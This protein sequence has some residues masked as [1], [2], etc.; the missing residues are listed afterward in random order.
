L[1]ASDEVSVVPYVLSFRAS[2]SAD[3]RRLPLPARPALELWGRFGRPRVDHRL[4][5]ADLVHGTNYV[6]PPSRRPR[7]VSVYDC[8]ALENLGRV[9]ADVRAAMRVLRRSIDEGAHVHAS[10]HATAERLRG[11]FPDCDVTVVHLGDLTVLSRGPTE[12]ADIP[13][14][15]VGGSPYVVSIGTRE[16]RKN[17]ATLVRAFGAVAAAHSDVRLVLAGGAGDDD[18]V[19]DAAIA[20]LDADARDRVVV[21]GRVSDATATWL[22]DRAAVLAYP[23]LDEGFGFPLLEAMAHGTPIV[24]SRVGSIPEVAGDAA[25]LVGATETDAWSEAII[26]LLTDSELVGDLIARGTAQRQ[27]FSWERTTKQMIELYRRVAASGS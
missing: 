14:E 7:L 19:I 22:L 10:S 26:R 21:L 18:P 23:S 17:L 12:G 27:Q 3:T 16:R 9:H 24:A 15:L 5:G 25:L 11:H 6:V 20:N 8:W 13:K 1:Q 4:D 2:L